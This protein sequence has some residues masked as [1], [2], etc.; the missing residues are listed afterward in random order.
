VVP[1]FTVVVIA[2]QAMA[3]GRARGALPV[4]RRSEGRRV[5]AL[6]AQRI[7][8]HAIGV[9]ILKGLVDRLMSAG[10]AAAVAS[11]PNVVSQGSRQKRPSCCAVPLT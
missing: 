3:E 4:A 11:A 6:A 1:A 9:K 10:W 2:E 5:G 8:R 7:A